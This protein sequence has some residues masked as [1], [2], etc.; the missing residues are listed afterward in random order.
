M[1]V[2][3]ISTKIP[4]AILAIDDAIAALRAT[5][6]PIAEKRTMIADRLAR[7]R[8]HLKSIDRTI[9]DRKAH[10]RFVDRRG[11][12]DVIASEVRRGR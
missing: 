2:N 3:R 4:D 9:A 10:K 6:P 5:L 7:H 8:D 11:L 1:T 12:G